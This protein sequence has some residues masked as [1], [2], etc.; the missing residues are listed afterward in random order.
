MYAAHFAA[1]LALK[2]RAPRVPMMAFLIG[3]FVLDILWIVFDVLD[4]DRLPLND[5]SHSLL[6][7]IVWSSV[8]AA[9]FR[10]FG[11][12]AFVAVWLTVFSH[13][14]LDLLVQGATLLPGASGRLIIAAPVVEHARILQVGLCGMLLGVYLHDASRASVPAWRALLVSSIVLALNLR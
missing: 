3:A 8:F 5:W 1:G 10:R 6:M 11:S 2:G 14:V 12:R 4:V 9:F 7:A 13:F